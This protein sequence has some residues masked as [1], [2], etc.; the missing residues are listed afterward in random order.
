LEK[1]T[2]A[3]NDKLNIFLLNKFMTNKFITNKFMEI[4]KYI[5]K[6]SIMEYY[7]TQN[8]CDIIDKNNKKELEFIKNN[9]Y[10]LGLNNKLGNNSFNILLNNKKFD[11]IKSLIKTDETILNFCNHFEYNLLQSLIYYEVMHET[12][13]N[14]LKNNNNK[15]FIKE[16]ILQK[17]A[18][19]INFIDL[20]VDMINIDN[21]QNNNNI[22]QIINILKELNSNNQEN[23]YFILTKLC[24]NVQNDKKLLLILEKL[25]VN[26]IDIFSDEYYNTCIDYLISNKLFNSLSFLIKKINVIFFENY[27]NN[28]LYYLIENYS[29]MLDIIFLIMDKC[30]FHLLKNKKDEN[31]LFKLLK[32]YDIDYKIIKKYI[33]KFDIFAQNIN[34]LNLYD[35]LLK[36]YKNN[37]KN[38]L[39][40]EYEINSLIKFKNP[41]DINIKIINDNFNMKNM[42]IKTNNGSFNSNTVHYIIYLL[43]CLNK[44]DFTIPYDKDY[45]KNK[46]IKQS[47]NDSNFMKLIYQFYGNI[48][49]IFPHLVIW[50]D[51]DNY[52]FHPKLIDLIKKTKYNYVYLKLT[53]IITLPDNSYVRHANIIIIDKKNKI[54]ERFEPYGNLTNT[55]NKELNQ[56][57]TEKICDKL[58][59]KY[60]YCNPYA[61]FQ[62]LSD[63]YGEYNRTTN[64]ASGYC[65]AWCILYLELKLKY[66][67]DCYKIISLIKNY[68]LNKF[69]ND[70]KIKDNNNIYMIFIRYYTKYL[71]EEKNK[72]INKCDINT[73]VIYHTNL[74]NKEFK[75]IF[76][77]LNKK[78]SKNI[79]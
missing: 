52:Y 23:T 51:K 56:I 43:M 31:I 67:Y 10:L 21:N 66:G 45:T 18:D 1:C 2:C 62:T 46:L 68:I 40:D 14:I 64:D 74:K 53:L 39:S 4:D 25:H 29:D 70:F 30:D 36:K 42:L 32:K 73:N 59:Y 61:G 69:V 50:K 11:F 24:K 55:F 12:I 5:K 7:I 3:E 60:V 33:S 63:E 15:H 78:I 35:L 38:I 6:V 34:G 17:N 20:C 37:I 48:N 77:C 79:N 16:L 72:I 26:N 27:D 19:N 28:S 71:D 8:I 54:V 49:E 58:K 65:L 41:F 22:K 13:L 75:Q 44:Y 47:N 76:K 57:I 9:I